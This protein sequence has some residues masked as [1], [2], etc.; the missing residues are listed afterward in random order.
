MKMNSKTQRSWFALI[1]CLMSIGVIA[2]VGV[3]CS[4]SMKMINCRETFAEFY[5]DPSVARK[6]VPPGYNVRIYPNGKA[7]LLM[8]EQDCERCVL[9]HL[10]TI[11]PMRMSH[12]WIELDG[13]AEVGP[14]LY[15][16]AES[17]PTSY[18]YSLPHQMDSSLAHIAFS[19]VGID[20]QH[21][22]MIN[23]SGQP[24]EQQRGVVVE[25]EGGAKYVWTEKSQIWPTPKLVTGRRWFY[26]E[27]GQNRKT[28]SKGLVTCKASFIGEGTIELEA[29]ANSSIGALGFGTELQGTS[30]VVKIECDVLIDVQGK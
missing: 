19:L 9:K 3:G 17:L 6:N 23:F 16:T 14:P 18:W 22:A 1:C 15:G 13:P 5:V 29:D 10:L 4:S 20:T 21:V 11:H 2:A 7:M 27:Y 28:E 25:N 30:N 24:G 26:R 8:L 12:L